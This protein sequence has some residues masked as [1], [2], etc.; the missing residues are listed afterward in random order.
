MI[1][2]HHLIFFMFFKIVRCPA[3][4]NPTSCDHK[5]QELIMESTLQSKHVFFL[6]L[7]N[8]FLVNILCFVTFKII[9]LN[10][11][12]NGFLDIG[13]LFKFIELI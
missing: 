12:E 11:T 2:S 8:D 10:E 6:E 7:K 1:I 13:F 4:I 5:I 3:D 9:E